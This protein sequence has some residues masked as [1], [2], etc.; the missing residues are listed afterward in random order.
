MSTIKQIMSFIINEKGQGNIF[1]ELN[2][3]MKMLMKG[4]NVKGILE[5]K[6]PDTPALIERLK[7]IVKEFDVDLPQ[8]MT[9]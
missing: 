2:V 3:Q 6:I 9:T 8:M 1:S 4:V 7:E 5:D